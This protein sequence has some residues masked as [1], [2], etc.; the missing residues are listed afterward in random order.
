M[1][2]HTNL[3]GRLRNTSLAKSNGLL[4]VFETIVNSIHALEERGNLTTTGTITL[5]IER[6]QQR[7]LIQD[8]SHLNEIKCFIIEDNGIG[9]NDANMKSFETLDSDHK[10]E[11]GCRGVGRLLWLKVFDYVEIFSSF[12]DA[13]NTTK[14][15]R[16]TFDTK[17]GVVNELL[18]E[19]D[20]NK[21][22]RTYVHLNGF[23]NKYRENTHK[24]A[25]SIARSLLEHCLWY[26]VRAEGVPNIKVQDNLDNIILNDLYNLYMHESA[27]SESITINEHDFYL[28]HIKFRASSSKKHS[29]SLCADGRLVKEEM[30]SGKIPGLFG[31]LSDKNGEFIYSCYVSSQYLDYRVRSERTSF[32]IAENVDDLLSNTEITLKTIRERVLER[33]KEYLRKYLDKNIVEGK[34]RVDKFVAEKAPR[35]R[36]IIPYIRQDEL[37][38]DPN[39]SD[40]ELE[41]HLHKQLAEVERIMIEQ[42]H[43]I[44]ANSVA[45]VDD[46]REMLDKYLKTAEDIKKSDLANYVSHRRV[47][48]DLLEKAI[49]KT[50]TGG[51]AREDFIH[52]LIMPMRKDSNDVWHDAYNLWLIDERLAFHNYLASDKTLNSI[53][54][55]GD[56]STKEPDICSLNVYDNPILVSEKQI[57]PLASITVIEIKR[58]MRN[59]A[60]AGEEKDPIEQSLNYLNRI[61]DGDVTTANG[62]PIPN[63]KEIP[64]YCYVICDLTSSIIQRC[65]L[66]GLTITHDHMGYFGYNPNYKA[67]I[68]V[69]SYDKLVNTAKERNRAFFD[70]L[71]LPAT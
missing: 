43:E 62:R 49:Q 19:V 56:T 15:R 47:I 36:S 57:P 60:K 53:P 1:S 20:I 14:T 68:E 7:S 59:D 61:R 23:E 65:N 29:L 67:Y 13:C 33:S 54:I 9:F 34:E 69:I 11:K 38:I 12:K 41:L 26:F 6:E 50:A 22:I 35:Y 39:I 21:E 2:L 63:S 55:T 71:G 27:Y 4:P 16:I 5:K 46:Y 18:E 42:G 51:Y 37:A 3:Q 17:N 31:K 8:D 70:K 32:D 45:D 24:S 10:I 58:P 30:I 52:K 44:M 66:F 48:I 64:G 25:E 40:K 28:I